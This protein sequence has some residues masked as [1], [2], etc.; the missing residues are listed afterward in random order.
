MRTPIRRLFPLLAM[1]LVVLMALA[2]SGGGQEAGGV[3]KDSSTD[4][5]GVEDQGSAKDPTGDEDS[6]PN[7]P[8]S[9][10]QRPVEPTPERLALAPN[11]VLRLSSERS[12]EVET[13]RGTFDMEASSGSFVMEMGGEYAFQS[14]NTMYMTMDLFGQT[15]NML[16][17]LPDFY[18]QVPGEGWFVGSGDALGVD[19]EAFQQYAEQRGLV[20]YSGLTEQVE[21]LSQLPDETIDGVTYL[22]YRGQLDI[23]KL[24]EDLP[25][26]LIDPSVLGDVQ[27]AVQS[28][29]VDLWVDADT[30]LPYRTDMSMEVSGG[31][32][33]F[34]MQMSMLSFDYNKPVD[35][36]AAPADAK[37]IDLLSG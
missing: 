14:P 27:D 26:G 9:D 19:F 23:A 1:M 32:F 4:G 15:M 34:S 11:E 22:R 7:D 10:N 24:M 16:M 29:G 30:Y 3:K 36:P 31:G 8:S 18:I 25:G 33:P 12:L 35:I 37:P 21:G 17:V 28:I 2:C 6:S 13:F 20:D 5:S